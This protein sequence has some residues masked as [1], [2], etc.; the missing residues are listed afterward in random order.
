MKEPMV[1]T[2]THRTGAGIVLF[3]A[4]VVGVLALT[5]VGA[6]AGYQWRYSDRIYEGVDSAGLPLGG[7]TL[8]E[9]T[10]AIRS[11]LSPYPGAPLSLAY[12][13][14]EWLLSSS[15]LGV[16]VDAAATA[17]D[18]FAAGRR[19]ASSAQGSLIALWAGMQEDL[20]T[21]WAA[22]RYG[23]HI[24][25]T[26]SL[27]ENQLALTLRRV[28]QEIDLPAQEGSLDIAGLEVS[29]RPGRAGR[30]VDQQATWRALVAGARAGG[31]GAV[32]L[33]VRELRPAVMEVDAAVAQAREF[34]GRSLIL[35]ADGLDG[36]QSFAV[37]P[38]QLR[39]WL[40]VSPRVGQDGSVELAVTSDRDPITAF[41]QMLALQ[42][43]RPAIDAVLDFD[44]EA[45]QVVVLEPSQ[46]GQAL[47]VAGSAAAIEA[48]LARAPQGASTAGNG[49]AAPEQVALTVQ[50]VAP[51]IDSNKIAEMGIVEL[52]SEGTTYFA[53]SSAERR[54]NI[55]NAVEK[56]RGAVI[57]PGEEFSFYQVVGDVTLANGFVD[58]LV[59]V[60][61][62][63]EMGVGGGVCQVSTTVF[64]AA[65]WAGVPVLERYAHGYVVGWYGEPGMDAAIFT[66]DA[67]FRF[68]N[69]TGHYLLIQ[70][71]LDLKKGRL[72]FRIYG[73]KDRS[74]AAEKGSITN[75][76]PAP[77][78]LYREDATLAAGTIK[79][80][81]WAVEGMD[82]TVERIITYNDGRVKKDRFVSRYRPWQAVYLYGPGAALPPGATQ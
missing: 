60:G 34:L 52:V 64:R 42:I 2:T 18:A 51:R 21:Q 25:P 74:V 47:D 14:R 17:A 3:L 58:A 79:Q 20:A 23:H 27:D 9:A 44:R 71:E 82:V 55:V 29:G 46:A 49:L 6:V 70:P 31:G 77:A 56:F 66:P 65:F 36:R 81:D 8:D 59:I 12:G 73:A 54:R 67:D 53:G 45:Q 78:P 57:P 10:E 69:D 61:D 80:V 1:T 43:D 50:P 40:T 30:Q 5:A 4:L 19:G 76:R 63:T 11:A 48:A 28:A 22:L 16:A 72:T 7:L 39:Q 35:V 32:P 62:R 75:R 24:S 68:L 15:D 38:A 41:V 37:D 13:E 33:V 26:L